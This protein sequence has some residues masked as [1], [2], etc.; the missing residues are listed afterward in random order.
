[1]SN[2]TNNIFSSSSLTANS[3]QNLEYAR[4]VKAI[5]EIKASIDRKKPKTFNIKKNLSNAPF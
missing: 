3:H 1:M 2:F 4:H 5:K